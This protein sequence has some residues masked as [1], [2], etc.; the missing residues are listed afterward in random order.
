M[1]F[2]AVIVRAS[3]EY[4]SETFMTTNMSFAVRSNFSHRQSDGITQFYTARS[5]NST[6][7]HFDAMKEV[8]DSEIELDTMRK[9]E[10]GHAKQCEAM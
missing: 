2:S 1:V 5:I 10:A 6:E 9:M 8:Q 7:H 3:R 4:H